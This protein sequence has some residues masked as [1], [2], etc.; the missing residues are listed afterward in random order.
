MQELDKK[1]NLSN[2]ESADQVILLFDTQEQKL[3]REQKYDLV[4]QAETVDQL[5]SA[6]YKISHNGRIQGRVKEFDVARMAA[7]IRNFLTSDF[8]ISPN[9]ATREFGIRQQMLYIKY[10]Q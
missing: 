4:N 10:Y 8:P 1:L 9:V 5:I 3:T 7:G 2:S 6:L